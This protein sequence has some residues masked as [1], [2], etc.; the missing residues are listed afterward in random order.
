[1]NAVVWNGENTDDVVRR[2]VDWDTSLCCI[3]REFTNRLTG[4]RT[5]EI[6]PADTMRGRPAIITINQPVVLMKD[7]YRRFLRQE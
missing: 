3:W 4:E 1:M 2:C 7:G 5:L 6:E